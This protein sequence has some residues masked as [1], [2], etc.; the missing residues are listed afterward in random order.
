M[1][2]QQVIACWT[3]G[4]G[5]R[6][7]VRLARLRLALGPDDELDAGQGQQVAQLGRVEEIRSDQ[8]RA[9]RG[10]CRSRTITARDPVALDLGPHRLVLE[11]DQQPSRRR[12]GGEHRGEDR[13]RDLRLV[14]EPRDPAPARV[15]EGVGL[16]PRR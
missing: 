6:R 14:A 4:R 11:Q 16:R 5:S 7:G 15:E 12:M 13:Q 10:S 8:R 1:A 2:K 3:S 9:R